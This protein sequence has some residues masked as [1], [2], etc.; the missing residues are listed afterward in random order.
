MDRFKI[1]ASYDA[2]LFEWEICYTKVRC[3]CPL[4][5]VCRLCETDWKSF[6]RPQFEKV[7]K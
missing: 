4:S 7:Y 3:L 5:E 2:L 1:D 6:E